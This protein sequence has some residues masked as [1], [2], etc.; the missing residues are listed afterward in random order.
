MERSLKPSVK[1]LWDRFYPGYTDKAFLDAVE[2]CLRPEHTVLEIGAGSGQGDQRNLQLKGQVRKVVGIDLDPRVLEH[3]GLDEAHVADA[4]D[5]PFADSSFDLVLHI[6][7]AEHVQRPD[8]FVAECA[9]V[10]R[11][12]G[13]LLFGTPNRFYYPMLIARLTPHRFHSYCVRRFGSGRKEHDVFPT[14]YRMNDRRTISRLCHRHEL[15]ADIILLSSPPGYL[16]FNACAFL[17][18][19]AYER[20]IERLFPGLRAAIICRAKKAAI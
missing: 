17:L 5:L 15:N 4:E 14:Y 11:P 13:W 18:G 19:V 1:R 9:R 2:V 6:N 20:T 12:G 8:V 10:L 7:V 3:P 16:R